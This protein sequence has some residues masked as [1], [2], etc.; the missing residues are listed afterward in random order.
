MKNRSAIINLTDENFESKVIGS[1][2]LFMV[3]LRAEWYGS[4]HIMS[5][6]I[7]ELALKF[8]G[9]VKIGIL[10]VEKNTKIPTRYGIHTVP[11]LLLFYN[12]EIVEQIFGAISRKELSE[13]IIALLQQEFG[14]NNEHKR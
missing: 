6:V 8:N 7:E 2:I 4:C 1:K 3:S 12:G 10:D 14:G 5:P 9:Q 13:K 11:A